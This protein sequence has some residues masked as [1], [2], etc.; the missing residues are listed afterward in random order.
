M[1]LLLIFNSEGTSLTLVVEDGSGKADADT[2]VSLSVFQAYCAAQGYSLTGFDGE[3]AQ[4]PAIRRGTTY[5]SSAIT[6]P[7]MRAH[8]REQALAW[9]REG[10]QDAE[11]WDV[12]SDEVPVEVRMATC[13]AAYYELRNPGGLNPAV[14]LTQQVKAKGIGPIRKEFFAGPMT[15]EA[16]RPVLTKISDLLAPLLS[17]QGANALVGAAVRR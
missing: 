12:P 11:G 10:V 5:L 9:P 2:F 17:G 15:A 6:W 4:E 7:G 3:T 13:E 14:N 16:A 8:G 1:S